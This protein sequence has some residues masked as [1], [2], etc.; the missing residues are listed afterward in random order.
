MNKTL[1]QIAVQAYCDELSRGSDSMNVASDLEPYEVRCIEAAA[2]AIIEE[3]AKIADDEDGNF[4]WAGEHRNMV[5]LQTCAKEI[6]SAIRA[7]KTQATGGE[8]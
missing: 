5:L 7:L 4:T 2:N 8:E 3:C 6:A 1:A